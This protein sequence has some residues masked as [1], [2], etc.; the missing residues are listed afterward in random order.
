MSIFAAYKL[1]KNNIK[2]IFI[3]LSIGIVIGAIITF[4]IPKEYNSKMILTPENSSTTTTYGLTQL[5][6]VDLAQGF[7]NFS[8]SY[9][10]TKDAIYPLIYPLFFESEAYQKQFL[11]IQVD[12]KGHSKTLRDYIK[13]NTSYPW[14]H[15]ILAF[16][17]LGK[18]EEKENKYN[19]S[20]VNN[21]V[22][23][24]ED[25]RL[26]KVL[27]NRITLTV[28][29]K[30]FVM[31]ISATF[32]DPLV[33]TQVAM[34]VSEL[35]KQTIK[36][37]RKD[38]YLQNY[39]FIKNIFEHNQ[40][41]Y[42]SILSLYYDFKDHHNGMLTGSYR[43]ED[44]RLNREVKIKRSLLNQITTQMQETRAKIAEDRPVFAI[45]SPATV[46]IK[47]SYPRPLIFIMGFCLV[48][49][50]LSLIYI[51]QYKKSNSDVE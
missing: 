35:L 41:E 38:K 44:E 15:Y 43:A 29:K 4:S 19:N 36:E 40:K 39:Q 17:S 26:I 31:E 48:S 2:T 47:P 7:E 12:Y 13:E 30:T 34:A 25:L 11:N 45:L 8:K 23:S 14:W 46:P 5:F 10:S 50:I 6:S 20:D 37:Y 22:I 33:A 28:D 3:F 32:Q 24:E 49:I 18:D 1:I 27:R 9:T 16:S 21:A 51:F 42:D